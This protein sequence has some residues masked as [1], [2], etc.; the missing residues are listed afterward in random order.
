M[1]CCLWPSAFSPC[2]LCPNLQKPLE[3][4]GIEDFSKIKF[5]LSLPVQKDFFNFPLIIRLLIRVVVWS[6]ILIV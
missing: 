5:A 1:I 4:N 6:H 3:P 2:C